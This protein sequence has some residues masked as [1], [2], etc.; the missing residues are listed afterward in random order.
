[1][2]RKIF[3]GSSEE[4]QAIAEI[5]E[6]RILTN[7]SDWLLPVKWKDDNV[8]TFNQSTLQCLLKNA[9]KYEYGIFI[10]TKDDVIIKRKIF[11]R[12]MRDNV[13][14][15]LGL[16]L[17]SLGFKR[18]F[19]LA[20]KKTKLP[21][22]L[23]G[24]T[25]SIFDNN[26]KLEQQIDRVIKTIEKTK[27]SFNFR[28]IPSTAL[29]FGYFNNYISPVARIIKSKQL[30]KAFF[31][32]IPKVISNLNEKVEKEIQTTNSEKIVLGKNDRPTIY[33]TSKGVFWDIPTNLV[34]LHEI[35][36]KL[37]PNE[38]V[39]YRED[40][41]EIIEHELRNFAGTLEFLVKND[42]STKD[43]IFIEDLN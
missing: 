32:K 16:F 2:K 9:R 19:L 17:G 28:I 21:S 22:D 36:D 13:L 41:Q 3:I 10:A 4:G 5:V 35:I 23:A 1:M 11:K 15:E 12:V 31:V 30:E 40:Y 7:C 42:E 39:G 33:K 25:I 8:F 24:T 34:T 27:E 20:N 29:A 6:K 37:F 26:K 14:F 43:L 38:E 18:T